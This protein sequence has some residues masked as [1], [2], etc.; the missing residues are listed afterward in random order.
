MVLLVIATLVI[1]RS[2]SAIRQRNLFFSI[3]FCIGCLFFV[4]SPIAY[5]QVPNRLYCTMKLAMPLVGIAL[6]HT[7]LLG[8]EMLIAYVFWSANK[9]I[10]RTSVDFYKIPIF[11]FIVLNLIQIVRI[12]T[13]YY[14]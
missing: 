8:R 10:R 5:V 4:I 14:N 9:L 7:C 11:I 6:M 3:M 13:L 1:L 2:K 12:Y